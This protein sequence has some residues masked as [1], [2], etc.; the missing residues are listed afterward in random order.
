MTTL[1]SYE[2][3]LETSRRVNWRLEDLIEGGRRLDFSRPF[4]PETFAQTER[5]DFLRPAAGI[6]RSSSSWK[7]S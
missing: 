3:L 2:R 4:L 7:H 6:S 1:Q 5:L